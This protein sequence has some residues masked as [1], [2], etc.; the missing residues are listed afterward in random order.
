MHLRKFRSSAEPRNVIVAMR[1]PIL[2]ALLFLPSP[3]L[4][5]QGLG[6]DWPA[7]LGPSGNSVSPEKGIIA[8]WPEKGLRV[9]WHK[10]LGTGY[11]APVISQGKLFQFDRI[12]NQARLLCLDARTGQQI[13][14]FEYPTDFKDFFGYN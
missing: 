7:F 3:Y 14:K 5:A 12:G 10:D 1:T 2:L 13:W 8:P 11:G 6:S 9:L 4:C